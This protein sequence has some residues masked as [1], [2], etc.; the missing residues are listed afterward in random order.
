MNWTETATAQENGSYAHKKKPF[1]KSELE[2][3]RILF[4]CTAYC[5]VQKINTFVIFVFINA[6]FATSC[7]IQTGPKI[8]YATLPK[9]I[10]MKVTW[11]LIIFLT[12]NTILVNVL[13][14]ENWIVFD[15]S[16]GVVQLTPPHIPF[17]VFRYSYYSPSIEPWGLRGSIINADGQIVM[18]PSFFFNDV[19]RHDHHH[20]ILKMALDVVV[21]VINPLAIIIYKGI[22]RGFL[23]RK[24]AKVVTY[25]SKWALLPSVV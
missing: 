19:W 14:G 17:T 1:W 21:M 12:H 7:C 3:G 10:K 11:F 20:F 5:I 2:C 22:F 4:T 8:K 13:A 23:P 15:F 25:D 9:I 18:T 16:W 6:G 24:L